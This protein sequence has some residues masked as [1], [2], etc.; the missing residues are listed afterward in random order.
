MKNNKKI[1]LV[2]VV[3]IVFGFIVYLFYPKNKV[4]PPLIDQPD[5]TVS[6][7]V[8][9]NTDYG[10]NFSLPDNWQGYSII[11]NTWTGNILTN[12]APQ[13]G[14]KIIIRNPKWTEASHYE[15]LPILIFTIAQWNS[16][17]KEDFSV[18]AAPIQATEM[19]RNNAYVFALPPRW[20]FDYGIDFKEAQDIMRGN[21]IQAFD[22]DSSNLN[23]NSIK[24]ES[25][26]I[27]NATYIIDGKV[28]TLKKGISTVPVVPGSSS[29][30][31]TK[32]WGNE[33]KHDFDGDGRDDTAFILTQNTGGS[34]TFYYVVIALNMAR[35]YIGSNGFLL[36]D[37]IA[38]ESIT[39]SKNLSTPDVI[40]VNYMDRK[41]GEA[42]TVKPSVL[43]SVW[44][45]LDTKTLQFGEV[46]KNFEGEADPSK[47]TLGMKTWNWVNTI[48]SNDTIITPKTN[49]FALILKA[50]KTFS[51]TTD[52]NGVGGEYTLNGNKITFTR[53]MSTL[54]YCEG[55]QEQDYSKMLSQVQ[56]YMFTSK[57]E[58]VFDL[59]LDTG[60]MIFK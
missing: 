55:S 33:I 41:I 57:G 8:Y 46:M 6:S 15:D 51:A 29:M 12:T 48:Y 24:S 49:K 50:D 32:Y 20:D 3:I 25:T 38:P 22:I 1:L 59:K 53:M 34:G 58:L 28:V 45:K 47:M 36:G 56:S 26:D 16:Y 18:G 14:Q 17:L 11:K 4:T 37:R 60:S 9:K 35:G 43:K 52:C 7:V 19:A 39:M 27:K 2:L 5:I 13:S 23:Q 10:F 21:P 31:T 54:M 42:F 44:L 30:I 40:I